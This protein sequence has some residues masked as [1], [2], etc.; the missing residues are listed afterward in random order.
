MR[1][2]IIIG[3]GLAG[4]SLATALARAGVDVLLLEQRPQPRPKV[5]GEFLS[6]D[7]LL[8]LRS[9]GL[10]ERVAALNPAPMQTARLVDQTGLGLSLPL[11]GEAWGVSRSALD[12][13]L[14]EAAREAGSEVRTGVRAAQ[15]TAE[16]GGFR[17]ATQ[18]AWLQTR[19]VVGAWGRQTS[20]G[21]RS[22]QPPPTRLGWIGLKRHYLGVPPGDGGVE[23]YMVDGGYVGLAPVEGGQT[24][25][26]ALVRQPA[27]AAA[28]G[29]LDSFLEAACQQNPA[30]ATRLS[31]GRPVAGTEAAVSGVDT[32]CPL[33][34]WAG[35]PLIGDAAGVIPPLVGDGMAM[36]LR[37][38]ELT[39]SL[40]TRFLAGH[41][42]LGTW[43]DTYVR[44]LQAEFSPRLRLARRLQFW[45]LRPWACRGLLRLGHLLPPLA[46]CMVRAT[47]GPVTH[48]R[49]PLGGR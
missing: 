23:L 13:T 20:P 18:G 26:S 34:P 38:A 3:G 40:A 30:L 48:R 45:L 44:A 37:S 29:S 35:W 43:A 28:G 49:E 9:L 42:T 14:L 21:L 15:V 6:P 46:A 4:S 33:R 36:A 2:L 8:S 12:A 11:P 25:C 17:I 24:N 47:R 27:F 1:E 16:E 31:G 19:A 41:L 10:Y 7:A 39:C 5:C 32:Q 22:H